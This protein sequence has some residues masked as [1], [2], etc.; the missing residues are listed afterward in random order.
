[1]YLC[2]RTWQFSR[3][4]V[5]F[6][7][8]IGLGLEPHCYYTQ[9]CQAFLPFVGPQISILS[10]LSTM[11]PLRSCCCWLILARPAHSRPG[12]SIKSNG[13]LPMPEGQG[14]IG[15]RKGRRVGRLKS[16]LGADKQPWTL[17]W[18]GISCCYFLLPLNAAY[19]LL[20]RHGVWPR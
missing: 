19:I 9:D 13:F 6:G 5:A 16:S 4:G 17:P 1:M 3:S 12:Q 2:D 11:V 15:C 14:E 7:Q 8:A 10:S 20:Q 18:E